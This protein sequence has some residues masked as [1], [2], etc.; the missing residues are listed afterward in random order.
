MAWAQKL[1][2]R[3][4]KTWTVDAH[5]DSKY[6]VKRYVIYLHKVHLRKMVSSYFNINIDKIL[7][8]NS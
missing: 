4:V 7:S 1:A 5:K 2:K 8:L 6:Y 3:E